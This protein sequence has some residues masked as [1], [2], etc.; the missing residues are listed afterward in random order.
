M[1]WGTDG[2]KYHASN[3]IQSSG[4]TASYH[5]GEW[6]LDRGEEEDIKISKAKISGNTSK[7]FPQTP[8]DFLSLTSEL[9]AK[10][11]SYYTYTLNEE[12]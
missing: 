4:A 3:P 9:D 6:W 8:Q 7:V 5:R 2:G 12:K 11:T 10:K 1:S